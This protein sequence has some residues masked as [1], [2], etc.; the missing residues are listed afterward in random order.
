MSSVIPHSV[1][2]GIDAQHV[3]GKIKC[4]AAMVIIPLLLNARISLA[5]RA[6]ARA[7]GVHSG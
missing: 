2:L 1:E 5:F 7:E 4:L 3:S 6:R